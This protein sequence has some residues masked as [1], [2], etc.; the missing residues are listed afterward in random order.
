[1]SFNF[2]IVIDH[3]NFYIVQFINLLK[4]LNNKRADAF[5]YYKRLSIK[6]G[7]MKRTMS[8]SSYSLTLD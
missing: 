5:S 2:F 1:M 8:M 4:I 7:G 3:K 6:D